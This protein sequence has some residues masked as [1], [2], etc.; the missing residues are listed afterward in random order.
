MSK[1]SQAKSL[2]QEMATEIARIAQVRVVEIKPVRFSCMNSTSLQLVK[3]T[4][5]L[6]WLLN[7]HLMFDTDSLEAAAR[8][9]YVNAREHY[10]DDELVIRFGGTASVTVMT[11]S[12]YWCDDTDSGQGIL[13]FWALLKNPPV[14]VD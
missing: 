1:S 3:T 4:C 9:F 14:W 10:P 2:V 7:D 12:K 11:I 8:A 6:G 5:G 13:R